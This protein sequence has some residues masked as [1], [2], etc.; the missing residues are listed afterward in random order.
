[1]AGPA[2]YYDR[3]AT[4]EY[5]KGLDEASVPYSMT[6][7]EELRAPG[8]YAGMAEG[9]KAGMAGGASAGGTLTSAG[10]MGMMSGAAAGPYALAGGLALSAYEQKQ[11]ADAANERARVEEAQQRKAA[12][13]NAL[14]QLLA[15]TRNLGV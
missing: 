5:G 6:T 13:Q 1:M 14:N 12:T 10:L 3:F 4:N 11:Q 7:N 8:K 9:A 15:S 2:S